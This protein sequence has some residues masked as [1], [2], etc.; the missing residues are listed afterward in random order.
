MGR[1]WLMGNA[2]W[3][4][5][6][7]WGCVL[8]AQ[9]SWLLFAVAVGLLLHLALCPHP[10]LEA[11]ALLRVALGGCA[12]DTVLGVV[13]VFDFGHSPLPIWL[14]MLWLVFACGLRHS[15]AWASRPAWRGMLLGGIGGPLAYCA[16]APLAEVSLPMGVAGTVLV[17]APL[18]VI[19]MPLAFRLSGTR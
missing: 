19:W 5:L 18:W 12:M 1:A 15:L 17:L 4:Q 10:Q 13:G 7:W 16:G 8:G 6:G 14:V 11:G 2:L 3:L 9:V